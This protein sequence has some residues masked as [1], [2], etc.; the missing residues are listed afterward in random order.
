M[1]SASQISTPCQFCAT[2]REEVILRFTSMD[3]SD[4]ETPLGE[5]SEDPKCFRRRTGP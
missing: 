3:R 4:V 1:K 2:S 5:G